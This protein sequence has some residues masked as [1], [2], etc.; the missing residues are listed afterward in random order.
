MGW[1]GAQAKIE[2][3]VMIWHSQETVDWILWNSD[4][5]KWYATIVEKVGMYMPNTLPTAPL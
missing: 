4:K 2:F 3:N 5:N 1:G